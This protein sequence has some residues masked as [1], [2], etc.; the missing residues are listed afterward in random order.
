[1]P[2]QPLVDSPDL[3]PYG[4]RSS[5]RRREQNRIA[6]RQL[7]ERRQQQDAAQTAELQRRQNEIERLTQ[8]IQ[9][10]RNEN[11]RLKN[12]NIT[13]R[14]QSVIPI[15]S[16]SRCLSTG[17]YGSMPNIFS[18]V[19]PPL[20]PN[21]T[22]HYERHS[23]DFGTLQ[24][25]NDKSY[26]NG[27]VANPFNMSDYKSA[28]EQ[29][30]CNTDFSDCDTNA[31]S[32][33]TSYCSILPLNPI[34]SRERERLTSFSRLKKRTHQVSNDDEDFD[35]EWPPLKKMNSTAQ[36]PSDSHDASLAPSWFSV[37]P[38]NV[39]K[40][41]TPVI[42]PLVT[43]STL[44]LSPKQSSPINL[45]PSLP[46][47]SFLP[48]SLLISPRAQSCGTFDSYSPHSPSISPILPHQIPLGDDNVSMQIR[49]SS[50]SGS[51]D[52]SIS[53]SALSAVDG[54]SKFTPYNSHLMPF[55]RISLTSQ[56]L[57]GMKPAS[58]WESSSARV[59]CEEAQA[60]QN[61]GRIVKFGSS[62]QPPHLHH[63]PTFDGSNSSIHPGSSLSP[64]A[65]HMWGE[66]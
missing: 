21:S 7:R 65:L 39:F 10:L 51:S 16:V 62:P 32:P 40:M 24:R 19:P 22:F 53:N 44:E 49:K 13:R 27:L 25:S 58:S 34:A 18:Q 26:G 28:D 6:Q 20:D 4:Q 55:E 61:S 33:V 17:T 38:T 2:R 41:S 48:Q 66:V 56:E 15:S 47:S 36:L 42:K 11:A 23:I 12:Q 45:D 14:R 35:Y 57:L 43:S 31:T 29:A 9:E 50:T 52:T 59:D 60:T 46:L 37:P 8:I 1:M 5:E 54:Q 30:R 3:P 63:L 64:M